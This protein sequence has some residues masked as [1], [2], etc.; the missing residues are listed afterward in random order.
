MLQNVK[1]LL[2]G[3]FGSPTEGILSMPGNFVSQAY[4]SVAGQ[5]AKVID[6]TRRSTYDTTRLGIW[7]RK[8][9]ARV[10]GLSYTL[11]PYLDIFGREQKNGGIMEQFISPGY[12]VAKTDDKV[13]AEL[14]KLYEATKET[15]I[16]PKVAPMKLTYKG[17]DIILKPKEI[18]AFQ[19][20]MGMM[21][22]QKL[23]AL[24]DDPE[25]QNASDSSKQSM[26]KSIVTNS[27]NQTKQAFI[28]K[29][30]TK[31]E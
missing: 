8:Q 11:E 26:V 4:P 17:E 21:N 27:Y 12:F 6:P 28:Q 13:T 22:Y 20:Q 7:A 31:E 18:T 25:Y 16:I 2:G 30:E 10:P 5:A 15:D 9:A 24:F 23:S 29:R 14:M 19:R 3:E 1:N